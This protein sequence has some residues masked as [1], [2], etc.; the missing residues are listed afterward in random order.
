MIALSFL[1][2]LKE[3]EPNYGRESVNSP[4]NPGVSSNK[5]KVKPSAQTT[6]TKMHPAPTFRKYLDLESMPLQGH[7]ESI[8][9]FNSS[10]ILQLLCPEVL[11][12]RSLSSKDS[13]CDLFL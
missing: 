13:A 12:V 4:K 9:F 10:N 3:H 8:P 6:I 5:G 2:A 1:P 11:Y 7:S